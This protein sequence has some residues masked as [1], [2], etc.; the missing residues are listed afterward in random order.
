[1][2]RSKPA[3]TDV[4]FFASDAGLLLERLVAAGV[5][6]ARDIASARRALALE[7]E[8]VERRIDELK[9]MSPE[10]GPKVSRRVASAGRVGSKNRTA[11]K[12]RRT[13]SN[14]ELLKIK[15]LQGRYLGLSHKVAKGDLSKFKSRIA[16]EGKAA[17]VAA[18][19]AYVEKLPPTASKLRPVR[20]RRRRKAEK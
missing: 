7:A 13:R 8:Q 18:M 17:V 12:R 5:V 10:N 20:K 9:A 16:T 11:R 3:S 4:A 14:A 19:Q 15:K 1:M 2:P 6:K